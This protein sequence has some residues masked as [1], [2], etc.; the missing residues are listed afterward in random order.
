MLR[1]SLLKVSTKDV[2]HVRRAVE[3]ISSDYPF[4][5]A[6]GSATT[7]EECARASQNLFEMLLKHDQYV[8]NFEVLCSVARN[9]DGTSNKKKILELVKLF[10]PN[11]NGEISKLDFVK[12][13][14]RYV[15]KNLNLFLQQ[16]IHVISN[17]FPPPCSVYKRLRLVLANI[18][19]SSQIDRA[20]K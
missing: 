17:T 11:R 5:P 3:F 10:R 19:N 15:N 16:F 18:K 12:S 2:L 7:R 4:S 13:I 9:A 14:D 6:F 8:L 1:I 20:C